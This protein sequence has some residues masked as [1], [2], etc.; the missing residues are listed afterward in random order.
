MQNILE[1]E[2]KGKR[3]MTEFSKALLGIS[4]L[5]FVIIGCVL[6]DNVMSLGALHLVCY[7]I[8]CTGLVCILKVGECLCID[9]VKGEEEYV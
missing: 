9:K 4:A 2:R 3:N 5:L 7:I 1:Q 8:L 6:L